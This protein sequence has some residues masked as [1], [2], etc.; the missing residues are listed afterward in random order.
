MSSPDLKGIFAIGI[1]LL[2]TSVDAVTGK[3]LAQLGSVVGEITDS[4][5]AEWWQH[6]GFASRP[7]KAVAGK[8]S[9]QA[10]V[11]KRSDHDIC[12]ASQDPRSLEMYGNIS[13]GETCVYAAG[14]DGTSQGRILLKTDGSVSLFTTSTNLSSGD[15][16][17]ARVAKGTN[18]A[19]GAPDGFTWAA[20][21]G[22]NKF[23]DTGFHTVH[24]SGA[25]FHLGGIYG[26]PSP[27]DQISSY[28][29]IQVGTFH[30]SCS[31][32]SFGVVGATPLALEIPTAAALAALQTQI[33]ALQTECAA[34]A[35]P[36]T[37]LHV[38]AAGAATA[39]VAVGASA[40]STGAAA[41]AAQAL[42]M[43][44]TTAS[45]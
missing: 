12:V 21:W 22:T 8:S 14:E 23:D 37:G 36:L 18:A 5:N 35:A 38:T 43:P 33:T 44:A 19:T 29:K 45:T 28:C 6:V 31:G 7:S 4:D 11:I 16:V 1:D 10:V 25:E 27:L 13:D 3:I 42:L 15:S 24:T 26:M 20:P 30:V 9:A 39:G 17:Y 2:K 40:V 41:V 32:A 34:I